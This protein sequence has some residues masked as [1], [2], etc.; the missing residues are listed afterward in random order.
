[1]RSLLIDDLHAQY[2]A[3][4]SPVT[5]IDEVYDGIAA[6]ADPGMFISQIDRATAR[7]AAKALGAFD[8]V[9]APLWG[10]PFAVK[11]N[12]DVAAMPTTAACARSPRRG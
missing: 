3:G 1:M 5:V 10:V 8:P 9:L 12:I 11:D 4:L 6:A 7:D 2:R